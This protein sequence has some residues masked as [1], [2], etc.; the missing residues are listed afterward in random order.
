MARAVAAALAITLGACLAQPFEPESPSADS[1][2]AECGPAVALLVQRCSGCHS[3]SRPPDLSFSSGPLPAPYRDGADNERSLLLRKLTGDLAPSEGSRM[4]PGAP[5]PDDEI[6][7]VR[8]WLADGAP[9][10]CGEQ[11]PPT[12]DRHH[13]EGFAEPSQHGLELKLGRQDCRGC[14][15]P[16]LRGGVAPSCDSCHSTTPGQEEAWRT[17]CTFCHGDREAQIAAPPRDL[18]GTTLR[19]LISFRA[20]REHVSERNH[21]PYDCTQCHRKPESVLSPGHVFEDEDPTPGRAEVYF[22]GGHSAEGLYLGSGQCSNLYCH[23]NGRRDGAQLLGSFGHDLER[24]SCTS[25]HP[26]VAS[27][28]DGW[29]RMSGEHEEHLREAGI[30]CVDCHAATVGVDGLGIVTPER[31][32]NGGVE[33]VFSSGAMTR[34]QAGCTGEC[35]GERHSNRAW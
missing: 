6:E 5:L 29:G 21:A 12:V 8:V 27:G 34:T 4:P 11:L 18:D 19:A 13:P 9:V 10:R 35:H 7:L 2:A 17:D 23:G 15:G 20:H 24:P 16:E 31:H 33:V 26:G 1:G 14:H 3:A 25:C 32:V 30:S 28:R 22:G